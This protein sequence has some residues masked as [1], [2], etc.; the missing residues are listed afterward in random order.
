MYSFLQAPHLL[1][2]LEKY[3]GQIEKI[4][5]NGVVNGNNYDLYMASYDSMFLIMYIMPTAFALISFFFKNV[6]ANIL[7]MPHIVSLARKGILWW[8]ASHVKSVQNPCYIALKPC[9]FKWNNIVPYNLGVMLHGAWT[10]IYAQKL[11]MYIWMKKL[12]LWC[13]ILLYF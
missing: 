6:R 11:S 9:L 2:L 3:T 12:T 10:F 5:T 13:W 7:F 8:E 1:H 4:F